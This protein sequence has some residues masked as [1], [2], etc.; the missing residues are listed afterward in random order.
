MRCCAGPASPSRRRWQGLIA[1]VVAGLLLLA[2][3]PVQALEPQLW[4]L[5]DQAGRPWS[6]TLL[7]QADPAYPGGL[8]LRLTDRSGRGQLDHS[9]PL[10]LH[11]AFGGTWELVNRSEELV[12]AGEDARPTNTSQFD[13]IDLEPSPRAELPLVLAVPLASGEVAQLVAGAGVVAALHRAGEPH[14]R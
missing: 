4:T 2:S 6:I 13:L 11:D 14:A 9:Q 10:R 12:A 1:L 5:P 7:E 8:R 3:T